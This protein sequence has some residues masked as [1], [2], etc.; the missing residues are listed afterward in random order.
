MTEF[1]HPITRT[2]MSCDLSCG[3]C[4]SNI[5][6]DSC[7]GSRYLTS[8]NECVLLCPSPK[9]GV[10]ETNTCEN[11]CPDSKFKHNVDRKCYITCPE[12]YFGDIQMKMCVEIC[13]D[14]MW[15]DAKSKLCKFCLFNCAKCKDEETACDGI[16]SRN[17]LTGSTCINPSCNLD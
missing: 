12:I 3:T 11:D 2:C 5:H 1:I 15:A 14:G 13:P 8:S 16:C 10:D 7:I 4:S 6:C 17:W 9:Y